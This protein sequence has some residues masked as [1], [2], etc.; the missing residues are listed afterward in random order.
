MVSS[1]GS[2][3]RQ[4]SLQIFKESKT[5]STT[6]GCPTCQG[7]PPCST[8]STASPPCSSST[9]APCPPPSSPTTSIPTWCCQA[10]KRRVEANTTI[11]DS[12]KEVLKDFIEWLDSKP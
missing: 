7:T 9:S 6:R 4:A 11:P 12:Q 2:T 10:I 1:T 3:G 5:C 8:T